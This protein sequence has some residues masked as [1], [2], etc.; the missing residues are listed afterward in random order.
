MFLLEFFL[1]NMIDR[2]GFRS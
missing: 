1:C 2:I